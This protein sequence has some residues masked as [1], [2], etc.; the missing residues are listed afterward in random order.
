M[1]M[2]GKQNPFQSMRT[3]NRSNSQHRYEKKVNPFYG[4]ETLSRGWKKE[5]R[6]SGF[7]NEGGDCHR[8]ALVHRKGKGR[9]PSPSSYI[10][11]FNLDLTESEDMGRDG[12]GEGYPGALEGRGELQRVDFVEEMSPLPAPQPERVKQDPML[13]LKIE[14]LEV[15]IS[16]IE[17]NA[18]IKSTQKHKIPKKLQ[19]PAAETSR[20]AVSSIKIQQEKI[21]LTK[22]YLYLSKLSNPSRTRTADSTG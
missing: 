22:F 6:C 4:F 20:I 18:H 15:R 17:K 13:Q 11:S 5:H 19:N 16:K 3:T 10:Q 8:G 7:E 2:T 14:G 1:E 12:R 21:S 9:G